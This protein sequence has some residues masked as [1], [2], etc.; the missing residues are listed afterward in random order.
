[1][2]C[3]TPRLPLLSLQIQSG[4]TCELIV[5]DQ[6]FMFPFSFTDLL[7]LNPGLNCD[8]LS[9]LVGKQVSN[10]LQGLQLQRD[11]VHYSFL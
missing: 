1:M 7:F 2:S 4:D 11:T 3:L 9:A 6:S 5:S 10:N 8:N